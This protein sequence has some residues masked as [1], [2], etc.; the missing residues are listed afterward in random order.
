LNLRGG[1][2][3]EVG[4]RRSESLGLIELLL[5]LGEEEELIDFCGEERVRLLL[6]VEFDFILQEV[7]HR[8]T[9]LPTRERVSE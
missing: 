5:L 2:G 8:L 9:H 1:G 6:L 3:P 4:L 7:T